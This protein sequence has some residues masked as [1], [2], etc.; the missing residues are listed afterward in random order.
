MPLYYCAL[1]GFRIMSRNVAWVTNA[2]CVFTARLETT[3]KH[4]V[5]ALKLYFS[6]YE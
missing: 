5:N 3:I 1:L 2:S 6:F 4:S